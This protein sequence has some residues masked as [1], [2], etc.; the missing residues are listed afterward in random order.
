[1]GTRRF[2]AVGAHLCRQAG[3]KGEPL[4]Q[5]THFGPGSFSPARNPGEPQG[6]SP[7]KGRVTQPGP[8]IVEHE[9]W[10]TSVAN[11]PCCSLLP[12]RSVWI[13]RCAVIVPEG[14]WVACMPRALSLP[15]RWVRLRDTRGCAPMCR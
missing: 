13:L 5:R 12:T 1:V 7:L 3:L 6:T 2:P 8:V 15:C 10:Q 9:A 14:A 4:A 11:S